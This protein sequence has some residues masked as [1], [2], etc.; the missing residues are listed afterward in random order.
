MIEIICGTNRQHSVS[1]KIA[2]Q[3]QAILKVKDQSSS[4][5]DLSELPED[6][7]VSALYENAGKNPAFNVFRDQI[8]KAEKFV[9][10][11]PEYNGSF[12]GV[13]KAFIDGMKYPGSFYGKK[14]A[15]VGL[16]SG[17]QRGSIALSHLTDIFNYVGMNVLAQKPK[18]SSIEK[19]MTNDKV[20][21]HYHDLL[22]RQEYGLTRNYLILSAI[23]F[24]LK[25]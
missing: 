4:I 8:E 23:S 7:I 17:S 2:L 14:C 13:L 6:F 22:T 20:T 9:F 21:G 19:K 25:F 18:L 11:V 12:P 3:Y 15:L 16:S 10:I 1:R 24:I 5:M